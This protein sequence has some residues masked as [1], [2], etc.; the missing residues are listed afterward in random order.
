[1]YSIIC[2]RL[3]YTSQNWL[4]FIFLSI[5]QDSLQGSRHWKTKK[6]TI[7]T[8]NGISNLREPMTCKAGSRVLCHLTAKRYP[9]L[10]LCSGHFWSVSL[11]QSFTLNPSSV[12]TG[13]P[14]A[15]HSP[16]VISCW[17]EKQWGGK[18]S[19]EGRAIC[20]KSQKKLD[21]YVS[22]YVCRGQ[23][24]KLPQQF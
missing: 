16:A 6:Q 4:Q 20:S 9:I 8:W 10:A 17:S 12:S 19:E 1:M 11:R 15:E 21:F 18:W 23:A 7:L 24:T 14:P 3:R 2:R 22:F 5:P 13:G